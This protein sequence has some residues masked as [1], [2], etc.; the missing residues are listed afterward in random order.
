MIGMIKLTV[1]GTLTLIVLNIKDKC[2]PERR[3]I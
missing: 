1:N 3:N 2:V